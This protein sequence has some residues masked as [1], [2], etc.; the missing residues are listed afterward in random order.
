MNT[1]T[2][3]KLGPI[4]D[5]AVRFGDLT[6]LVGPQASG[7]SIF[8]QWLKLVQDIEPIKKQLADYGTDWERDP[9]AF[10]STY[11]GEGMEGTWSERSSQVLVDDK[12]FDLKPR[13]LRRRRKGTRAERVFL[14]PAQRVLTL[15]DGWPRPFGDYRSGD[16]YVV[17]AYSEKMRN[18]METELSRNPAL[19]PRANRLKVEYREMLNDSLFSGF[20][21]NVQRVNAQKR[22]ILQEGKKRLPYMV[23][24][25]GQR[26]FVPLLLGLYWLIPGAAVSK[27]EDLQWVVLEEL[28]MGL[29]PRAISTMLMLVLEL[30]H[31]GYRVCLS[32]HSPQVLEMI[33]AWQNLKQ[34]GADGGSLG[35]VLGAKLTPSVRKV[36][37]DVMQ[38]EIR[39]Y[40]FE[41]DKRVTEISGLNPDAKNDLE[42]S[43]GE[44][45]SF[46][47]RANRAVAESA[48][49]HEAEVA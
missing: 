16:P 2:I 38:K 23:W 31:R 24:S 21:L 45:L 48:S 10:L 22:L 17:R 40:F 49:E 8:L 26:E 14:V 28:E 39:A 47:D 42:A 1:L 44:L 33:W 41:R 27:R 19:F 3:R 11:F 43:W 13:L 7:K 6:V 36:F 30:L 37:D 4:S 9:S 32:S 5:A 25:A 34:N 29:H 46:T 18:L 15:R 20:E 12:E 35:K